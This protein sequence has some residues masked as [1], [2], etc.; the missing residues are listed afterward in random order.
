MA[1]LNYNDKS[2]EVDQEGYL[3]HFDDW[4]E[5]L[6]TFLAERDALSL[7]APHREVILFLR[8]YYAAYGIT[9]MNRVF[10]RSI[11]KRLGEE[12]GNDRYLYTLF[13]QGPVKQGARYAGL[14]KPTSCALQ[15]W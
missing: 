9:P 11:G 3:L 6:A 12:N 8:E 13:P 2:V 15:G 10:T 14:P 4:S 1:I 5:E 7:T